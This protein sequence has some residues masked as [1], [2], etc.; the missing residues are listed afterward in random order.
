MVE[1]SR[2]PLSGVFGLVAI[3]GVT[4]A[5]SSTSTSTSATG[6]ST[7]PS[8]AGEALVFDPSAFTEKT[9]TISTAAGD[10]EVAYRLYSKIP[11]VARP[12]DADYQSLTIAVPT[13]IDGTDV[14][15]SAAPILFEI[16]VGGYRDAR[17]C[18]ALQGGGESARGSPRSGRAC[19]RPDGPAARCTAA[20]WTAAPRWRT[21]RSTTRTTVA[22]RR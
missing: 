17:K 14:D 21:R 10:K 2:R 9:A 19:S 12:V 4:A 20:R 18:A 11:Y 1:M 15:A 7:T 22:A 16:P 13:R 5:C 3:A 8:A 6:A